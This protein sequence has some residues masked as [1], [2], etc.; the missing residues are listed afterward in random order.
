LKLFGKRAARSVAVQSE[1]ALFAQPLSRSIN[2]TDII[3]IN[4]ITDDLEKL[5]DLDNLEKDLSFKTSQTY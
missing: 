4:D 2:I 3:E 1:G 5:D